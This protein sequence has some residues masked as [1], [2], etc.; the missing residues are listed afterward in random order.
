MW[1]EGRFIGPSLTEPCVAWR[2]RRAGKLTAGFLCAADATHRRKGVS[3]TALARVLE[4]FRA[5]IHAKNAAKKGLRPKVAN[6]VRRIEFVREAT[7]SNRW[8]A[9][10]SRL[11]CP[12]SNAKHSNSYVV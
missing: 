4:I 9:E 7:G 8:A 12:S 6:I 10:C 11:G 3:A 5:P 2:R 1:G